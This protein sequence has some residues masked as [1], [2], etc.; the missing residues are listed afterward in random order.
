MMMESQ[1][2]RV[3]VAGVQQEIDDFKAAL[4]F[5]YE[6]RAPIQ[7]WR[8]LISTAPPAVSVKAY[9]E[10]TFSIASGRAPRLD[11]LEYH[12]VAFSNASERAPR[13]CPRLDVLELLRQHESEIARQRRG[14]DLFCTE[15][16]RAV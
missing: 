11:V 13:P 9:Y 1:E 12:G 7:V 2:N 14:G 8:H 16:S 10:L 3:D 5:A 6:Q 15:Q 4:Q